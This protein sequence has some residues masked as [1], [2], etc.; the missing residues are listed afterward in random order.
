MSK[1]ELLAELKSRAEHRRHQMGLLQ[2]ACLGVAA[3]SFLLTA[4]VD[5]DSDRQLILA[6]GLGLG[7]VGYAI[8]VGI[9]KL[10]TGRWNPIPLSRGNP[11]RAAEESQG[12]IKPIAADEWALWLTSAD[13]DHYQKAVALPDEP[14][15]QPT[16]KQPIIIPSIEPIEPAA[17]P[18]IESVIESD[19]DE[20]FG[21]IPFSAPTEEPTFE[22]VDIAAQISKS[23]R[24]VLLVAT[25]QSGKTTTKRAIA[26]RFYRDNP[27]GQLWVVDPKGSAIGGDRYVHL[28]GTADSL[29][30]S[31]R[32]LQ[33]A[34]AEMQARQQHR[35][36]QGGMWKGQRPAK[37]MVLIDELNVVL[38]TEE[39]LSAGLSVVRNGPTD[40]ISL[41]KLLVVQGAEDNVIL[42]VSAHTSRVEDLKLNTGILGNFGV[43]AQARDGQI[44]SIKDCLINRRLVSAIDYKSLLAK[45]AIAPDSG[46][47]AFSK[48]N[49]KPDLVL[50]PDYTVP[51]TDLLPDGLSWQEFLSE[52]KAASQSGQNWKTKL[53]EKYW[54]ISGGRKYQAARQLIDSAMGGVA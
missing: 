7:G 20:D 31:V 28:N 2:F 42:C 34:F 41:I 38:I 15:P 29:R 22:T 33:D 27:G 10:E 23:F 16:S 11:I 13:M 25:T 40:I 24:S 17:M 53:I 49:G 35:L 32:L 43:V 51:S 54:G 37:L 50:V 26:E 44:E 9:D 45:L 1:S 4:M 14:I 19:D 48:L 52:V 18:V 21:Y 39:S 46:V 30:D 3:G 36:S 8:T 5:R 12:I 47:I 6:L